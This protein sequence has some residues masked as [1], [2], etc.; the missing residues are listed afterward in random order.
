MCHWK[1]ALV[2]RNGDVIHSDVTDSHEDLISAYGLIDCGCEPSF[3][4]VE[5]A[6]TSGGKQSDIDAYALRVD[7]DIIPA[8]WDDAMRDDATR[9]L[10]AIVARAIVTD[11]R[12]TLL[13]GAWILDGS[14]N[15]AKAI[16][17]RVISMSGSSQVG[18]MSGSSQVGEMSGSSRVVFDKRIKA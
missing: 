7:Q 8:W 16:N 12:T 6:P 1:S 11:A 3:V 17:V 10:R 9:K 4:R 2:L 18:A 15:V 5:Y 14:V 13:G